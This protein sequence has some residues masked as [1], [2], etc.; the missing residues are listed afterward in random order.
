MP[1]RKKTQAERDQELAE[2]RVLKV[3]GSYD[4]P[5]FDACVRGE[6]L[7]IRRRRFWPPGALTEE[8]R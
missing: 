2:R 8:D 3:R 5:G 4:A 7:N 6:I 1:K